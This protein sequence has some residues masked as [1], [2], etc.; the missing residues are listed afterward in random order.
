MILGDLNTRLTDEVLRMRDNSAV[1]MTTGAYRKLKSDSWQ[2]KFNSLSVVIARS[3]NVTN[4]V[5]NWI[6]VNVVE[7]IH[8]PVNML[9]TCKGAAADAE[10]GGAAPGAGAQSDGH[11]RTQSGTERRQGLGVQEWPDGARY[12]GEFVNGFKH[13]EGKYT[14]PNGEVMWIFTA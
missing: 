13:G 4:F 7:E 10:R 8:A 9:S 11:G 5:L 3:F 12:E 2:L 1:A 6:Q 14:W